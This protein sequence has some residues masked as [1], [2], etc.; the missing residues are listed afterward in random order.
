MSEEK[1]YLIKA[2]HQMM[3]RVTQALTQ[4]RTQDLYRHIELAQEKAVELNELSREEAERIGEY[5]RRDLQDAAHFMNTTEQALADWMHFDLTLIEE[6]LLGMFQLMVDHT[7]QELANLAERAKQ[8]TEW[9]SGEITG[10]GSL[11]C[12]HCNQVISFHQPQ[13]IIS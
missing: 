11:Y 7:Q 1:S 9:V 3:N 6:Q 4:T 2:Y 13:F 12:A 8:A 10:P 5:L